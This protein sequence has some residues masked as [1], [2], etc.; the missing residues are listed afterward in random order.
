MTTKN[1]VTPVMNFNKPVD[2]VSKNQLKFFFAV[3]GGSH[4]SSHLCRF[5][6]LE[7][8]EGLTISLKEKP[9]E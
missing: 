1:H 5:F 7:E 6:W 8:E 3:G 2:H 4:L 9:S